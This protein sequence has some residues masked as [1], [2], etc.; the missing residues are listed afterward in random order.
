MS[1]TAAQQQAIRTRGNVLVVAGAGSGKTHTLIERACDCLLNETPPPALAELLLVTFTEAAAAEMRRRLRT[2]L[3]ERAQQSG[4]SRWAEQVALF[5]TAHIG[6]LHSFCFRLVSQHFH[7]LA[8]DPQL[9]VLPDAEARLL[10]GETLD[11]VLEDQFNTASPHVAAVQ[12]LLQVQA[13]GRDRTLRNLVLKVHR[14]SQSLPNPDAWFSRQF[15]IFELD[16]QDV[17]RKWHA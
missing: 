10:A 17:R 15:E 7:Q 11:A 3:E 13:A 5:D 16:L 9:N 8:L 2:R 6:T 1:F 12:Q 14:Y 4:D